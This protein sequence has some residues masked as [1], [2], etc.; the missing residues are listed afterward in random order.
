MFREFAIL[1]DVFRCASYG[2]PAECS[3]NMRVLKGGMSLTTSVRSL[4][5]PEWLDLVRSPAGDLSPEG[6]R[7]LETLEKRGALSTAL[8]QG[9]QTPVG[10]LDWLREAEASH[11][12]ERALSGMITA[13]T[14]IAAKARDRN[15]VSDVERLT[16]QGWWANERSSIN[17]EK[18]EEGFRQLLQPLMQRSPWLAFQDRNLNPSE[19]RYGRLIDLLLEATRHFAKPV[20]EIHRSATMGKYEAVSIDEWKALFTRAWGHRLL[21]SELQV[22]V[23]L[24]PWGKFHDRCV[25][26]RFVGF[27]V[28]DGFDMK[29]SRTLVSRLDKPLLD[30]LVR[31]FSVNTPGLC[32]QF[33][34]G[35]KRDA[36][37]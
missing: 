19:P 17:M 32:G 5:A 25:L 35:P 9:E 21:R 36:S 37:G 27:Q 31:Q 11:Q 34:L 29:P 4:R 14:E 3:A 26:S 2:S 20:I 22:E 15:L 8:P 18:N 33:V 24:W 7:L 10:D 13:H 23:F 6:R 16:G 12:G 28:G 1:P 30:D